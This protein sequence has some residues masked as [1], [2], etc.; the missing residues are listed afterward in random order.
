M[1]FFVRFSSDFHTFHLESSDFHAFSCIL[2]GFGASIMCLRR[3]FA[4]QGMLRTLTQEQKDEV[5]TNLACEKDLRPKKRS[6]S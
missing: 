4:A 2:G 1:G 3:R 5:A 6:I